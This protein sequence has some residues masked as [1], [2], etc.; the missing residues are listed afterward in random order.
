MPRSP[1]AAVLTI[2]LLVAAGVLLSGS[3]LA[4]T[5]AEGDPPG[6]H[7]VGTV[8]HP[9]ERLGESQHLV[10]IQVER[11]LAGS[12]DV[13]P[14]ERTMVLNS[15]YGATYFRGVDLRVG[16]RLETRG[17]EGEGGQCVVDT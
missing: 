5:A 12:A 2:G 1:T 13:A 10:A 11:E 7:W 8:T 14:G 16:L 4:A 9:A 3:T 17:F 6:C 15:T